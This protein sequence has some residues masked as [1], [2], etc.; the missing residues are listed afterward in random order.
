[1]RWNV[2]VNWTTGGGIDG[3][4][5]DDY[6]IYFGGIIGRGWLMYPS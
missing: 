4:D 1:M 6:E 3:G 5:V 2:K